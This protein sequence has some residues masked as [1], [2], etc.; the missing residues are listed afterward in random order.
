MKEECQRKEEKKEES[1]PLRTMQAAEQLLKKGDADM[2]A[3]YFWLAGNKFQ[4]IEEYELSG[5]AYEKA[6]YCYELDG[7]WDKAAN[8]YISAAKMYELAGLSAKAEGMKKNANDNV[9]KT[10]KV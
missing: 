2:A 10:K 5:R 9:E 7:L 8:E 4:E 3:V 1:A 6:A